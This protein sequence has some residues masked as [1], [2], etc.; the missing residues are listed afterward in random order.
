MY[1]KGIE[2]NPGQD[3]KDMLKYIEKSTEKNIVNQD[4]E[5]I[6]NLVN[7]VKQN[8]EVGISYMK[9]WEWEK[10]YRRESFEEGFSGLTDD[11]LDGC[12]NMG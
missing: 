10:I 2:G 1:T 4:I 11:G 5:T 9:S 3:L 8:K 7:E 6:H 12:P